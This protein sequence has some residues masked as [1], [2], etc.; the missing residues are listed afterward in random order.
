MAHDRIVAGLLDQVPFFPDPK[1]K[2]SYH[3]AADVLCWVLE[4][5][6]NPAFWENLKRLEEFQGPFVRGNN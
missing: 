5:D 3:I 1:V 2:E 6:H 4:H